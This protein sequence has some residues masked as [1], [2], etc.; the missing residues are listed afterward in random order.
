MPQHTRSSDFTRSP[1]R[2]VRGLH[3]ARQVTCLHGA[4]RKPVPGHKRNAP[5]KR[6]AFHWLALPVVQKPA[7]GA[8]SDCDCSA[9]HPPPFGLLTTVATCAFTHVYLQNRGR[10]TI[11]EAKLEGGC[12]CQLG[13]QRQAHLGKI[14]VVKRESISSFVHPDEEVFGPRTVDA[15]WAFFFLRRSNAIGPASSRTTRFACFTDRGL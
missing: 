3:Q 8:A 1:I 10:W 12:L 2:K 9:W 14:P 5:R 15:V 6:G 13:W 7:E 11:P 4:T